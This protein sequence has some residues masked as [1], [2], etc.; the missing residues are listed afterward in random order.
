VQPVR[1]L[2]PLHQQPKAWSIPEVRRLLSAADRSS[3]SLFWGSL[4][5]AAYD[6][7]LRLG[8]LLD[9][10]CDQVGRQIEV[11][12]EKTG[13]VVTVRLRPTT[14]QLVRRQIKGRAGCQP[15]WPLWGRREAFYRAFRRLVASSGIRP[16]TFRWIRRTAATQVERVKH[17]SSTE[18]LGHVS[19]ATTETWYLDRSQLC[20][21]PLPPL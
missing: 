13:R 7:G 20:H 14:L 11:L 17:G 3:R 2:R 15:V 6:S 10:R 1:K 12:Q 4:C 21:P 19:R 16:G 5:R 8:D 18:L 9:L